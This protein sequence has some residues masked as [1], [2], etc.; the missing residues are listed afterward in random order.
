MPCCNLW[1]LALD[2]L[3]RAFNPALLM[4]ASL[5]TSTQVDVNS[6]ANKPFCQCAAPEQRPPQAQL[7][8]RSPM[9]AQN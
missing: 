4:Y 2:V 8:V 1:H 7:R 5:V 6:A 3:G 9:Q